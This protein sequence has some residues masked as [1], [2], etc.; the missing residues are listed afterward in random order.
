MSAADTDVSVFDSHLAD[1]K[2]YLT[3]PWARIRY[4]VVAHVIDRHIASMGEGVRIL[5]VGGGGGADSVRLARLGHHVTIADY[6]AT[7]LTAARDQATASGVGDHLRTVHTSVADLA[8]HDLQEYD[9]VLC[10]FVIQYLEDPAAAVQAVAQC[11]RPNG[12]LSLIAPNPVSSVLVAAVRDVDPAAA[13]DRIS[14]TTAPTATFSHEVALIERATAERYLEQAD[15]SIVGRYGARAVIDL[16]ADHDAKYE[17]DTYA[18]IERLELAL[19]DRPPYRDMA[20]L[21]QLIA[22]KDSTRRCAV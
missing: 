21:W 20:A 5:D 4:A 14:A 15:C 18:A 22:I 16:I 3:E 17:P 7:M 6:S 13:L 2:H 1:W 8:S 11:L 12:L 19:C 9:V 10:H